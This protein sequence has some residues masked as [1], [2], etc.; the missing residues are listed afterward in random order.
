MDTHEARR[1]LDQERVRLDGLRARQ[2]QE[3]E[4]L[5]E[6]ALSQELDAGDDHIGDRAHYV[7]QREQESAIDTELEE[8]QAQLD[9]AMQRLED[10][11]YRQC[12]VCGQQISPERHQ[13]R[14]TATRCLE[15]A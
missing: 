3:V 6:M 15:H 4:D 7:T 1:R 14:P 12:E 11:T 5:D 9:H 10:G 8:L 2:Q 13:A